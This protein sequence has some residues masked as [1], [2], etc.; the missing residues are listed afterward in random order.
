MEDNILELVKQYI[1]SEER[2]SQTK[3]ALLTQK[4]NRQTKVLKQKISELEKKLYELEEYTNHNKPN[5]I[6]IKKYLGWI[7]GS[8]VILF[9]IAIFH[10]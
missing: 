4:H 1:A 9:T 2:C 8:S 3:I 5:K 10:A 6:N 7:I